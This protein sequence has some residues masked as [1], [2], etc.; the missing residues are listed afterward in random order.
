MRKVSSECTQ[1]ML[2]HTAVPLFLLREPPG[3]ASEDRVASARARGTARGSW[4][5]HKPATVGTLARVATTI[6]PKP[7]V[8]VCVAPLT[9]CRT[10]M[11]M[12]YEQK[13]SPS[14]G[15]YSSVTSQCQHGTPWL[16]GVSRRRCQQET[17]PSTRFP[18]LRPPCSPLLC[19]PSSCRCGT[20]ARVQEES[21]RKSRTRPHD[22][23]CGSVSTKAEGQI[24]RER[25]HM[26]AVGT[27][28]VRVHARACQQ[29]QR[30]HT[31]WLVPRQDEALDDDDAATDTTPLRPSI[32]DDPQET[33]RP[34]LSAVKGILSKSRLGT[35]GGVVGTGSGVGGA[36]GGPGDIEMRR[37][38]WADEAS[39]GAQ[40]LEE[41]FVIPSRPAR[42][43]RRITSASPSF[44]VLITVAL[45]L[46]LFWKAISAA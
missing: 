10:T 14:N 44:C 8:S 13:K 28:T 26:H 25:A 5:P 30:P 16:Q 4:L 34:R 17:M 35:G 39:E 37:L 46:F 7:A 1:N 18:T 11:P 20:G 41:E 38:V 22:C 6:A 42:L 23:G 2:P 36:G 43:K 15:S 19:L 33:A 27:S 29:R 3:L 32:T 31:T 21:C 12:L 45:A 24:G 40:P 9:S